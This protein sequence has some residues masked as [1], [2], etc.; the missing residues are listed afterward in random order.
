[1]SAPPFFAS[2]LFSASS[3]A[4]SS[5]AGIAGGEPEIHYGDGIVGKQLV[6]LFTVSIQI[7]AVKC[8]NFFRL[9]FSMGLPCRCR[10][11]H[12]AVR[13]ILHDLGVLLFQL[14]QLVLRFPDLCGR[15]LQQLHTHL[16]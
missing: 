8:G 10:N 15:L 9:S 6:L 1:M 11:A 13:W 14:G 7:L 16:R 3:S 4:S 12:I 2:S 5:H